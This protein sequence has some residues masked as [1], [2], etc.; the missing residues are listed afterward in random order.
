[1]K[2]AFAFAIWLALAPMAAAQDADQRPDLERA[3]RDLGSVFRASRWAPGFP[4][5]PGHTEFYAS[6]TVASEEPPTCLMQVLTLGDQLW[7]APVTPRHL[8]LSMRLRFL[9]SNDGAPLSAAS[10]D[11]TL[12]RCAEEPVGPHW[13]IADTDHIRESVAS[14]WAASGALHAIAAGR[15]SYGGVQIARRLPPRGEMRSLENFSKE[16]HDD[17]R[18]VRVTRWETDSFAATATFADRPMG[19]ACELAVHVAFANRYNRETRAS[20][21]HLESIEVGHVHCYIV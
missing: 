21:Q 18:F 13:F 14:A 5:G 4:T 19:S 1:M 15:T 9:T 6:A 16:A 17:V 10:R 7:G 8:G 11:E 20:A 3:R 12:R 2:A